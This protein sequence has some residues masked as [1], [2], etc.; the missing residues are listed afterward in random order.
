MGD[1]PFVV[2]NLG[3]KLSPEKA[4]LIYDMHKIYLE[5]NP[6]SASRLIMSSP[7]GGYGNPEI[8]Q[9]IENELFKLRNVCPR[10][11]FETLYE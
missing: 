1:S 7:G 6:G 3:E 9:L 5:I 10:A 2:I 11:R 8:G 4:E